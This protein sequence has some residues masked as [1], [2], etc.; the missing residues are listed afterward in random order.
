M[1]VFQ[2]PVL[3]NSDQCHP[4]AYAS[5]DIWIETRFTEKETAEAEAVRMRRDQPRHIIDWSFTGGRVI[6]HRAE[7]HWW[8]RGGGATDEE[9]HPLP[10]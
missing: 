3:Y 1:T 10:R 6:W 7:K 2:V 4:Q 5:D 9:D 8:Q